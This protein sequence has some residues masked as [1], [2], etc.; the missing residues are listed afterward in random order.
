MPDE[1]AELAAGRD[2]DE[3][4]HDD[5]VQAILRAREKHRN[6]PPAIQCE[7]GVAAVAFHPES[8]FISVGVYTGDATV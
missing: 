6:H 5:V 8:E 1:L 3:R 7:G 4:D 2:E